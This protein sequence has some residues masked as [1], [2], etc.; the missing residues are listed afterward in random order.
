MP[1]SFCNLSFLLNKSLNGICLFLILAISITKFMFICVWKSIRQMNDD[2]LSRFVLNLVVFLG[3]FFSLTVPRLNKP[4]RNQV[5]FWALKFSK[6]QKQNIKF[7]HTPK[8]Q[9]NFIHSFA[10]AS[11]SGWIK[12]VKAFYCVK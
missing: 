4:S 9:R 11:K 7:S 8:Q 5:I 12:K 3:L 1:V 6:S 10:L 2:L